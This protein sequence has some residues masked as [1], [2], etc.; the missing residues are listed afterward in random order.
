MAQS[1]PRNGVALSPEATWGREDRELR[2]ARSRYGVKLR[3]ALL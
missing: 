2:G 1:A 3:S